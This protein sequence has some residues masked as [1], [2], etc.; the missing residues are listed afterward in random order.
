MSSVTRCLVSDAGLTARLPLSEETDAGDVPAA[1]W[2]DIV[3]WF[4]GFAANL[5]T[6]VSARLS[7]S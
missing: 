2:F 3:T 4:S 7:E 6:W 5:V 1:K